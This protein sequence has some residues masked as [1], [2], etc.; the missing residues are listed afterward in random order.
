MTGSSKNLSDLLKCSDLALKSGRHRHKKKDHYYN[1][2]SDLQILY[3]VH[4]NNRSAS[5]AIMHYCYDCQRSFPRLRELRKHERVHRQRGECSECQVYFTSKEKEERHRREV[6]TR[7]FATQTEP[8]GKPSQPVGKPSQPRTSRP[9]IKD[10]RRSCWSKS[11]RHWRPAVAPSKP[12]PHKDLSSVAVSNGRMM[13]GVESD[14]DLDLND[15]IDLSFWA[16]LFPQRPSS[17]PP[18]FVWEYNVLWFKFTTHALFLFMF[19]S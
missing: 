5:L 14:V 8:V 9:V 7:S 16:T 3:K 11:R 10:Y 18:L 1:R 19:V 12:A 6:H 13:T 2:L 15:T 17:G 4:G